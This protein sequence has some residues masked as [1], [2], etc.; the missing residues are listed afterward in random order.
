M[1]GASAVKRLGACDR[2]EEGGAESCTS[3]AHPIHPAALRHTVTH[4]TSKNTH[5][6]TFDRPSVLLRLTV[7]LLQLLTPSTQPPHCHEG[8]PSHSAHAARVRR[9]HPSFTYGD[10]LPPITCSH[11]VP[12]FILHA[13]AQQLWGRA[14]TDYPVP[15]CILHPVSQHSIS[16]YLETQVECC[17]PSS[18]MGKSFHR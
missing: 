13:L 18:I 2:M 1:R 8:Q 14:S 3:F 7:R 10:E 16:E 11:P 6:H 17:T 4:T 9:P 15:H 12:H 5:A